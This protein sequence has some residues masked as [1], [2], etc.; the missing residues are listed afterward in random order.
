MAHDAGAVVVLEQEDVAG[1][2]GFDVPAVDE[3]D[4]GL[5]AEEGAADACRLRLACRDD[6]DPL[7]ELAGFGLPALDDI[8]PEALRDGGRV[9]LVSF[10]AAGAAEVAGEGSACEG[11]Q[12]VLGDFAAELD[13]KFLDAARGDMAEEVADA[14][15]EHKCRAEDREGFGINAGGIDGVTDFAME[16]SGADGLRNLDAHTLLSFDGGSAEMRG[17]DDV[18]KG[19]EGEVQWWRLDLE[20][21]E[22]RSSEVLALEGF[23]KGSF[24]NKATAGAIDDARAARQQGDAA[25][26]EDV[27]GFVRQRHVEGEEVHAGEE[28]VEIINELGLDG[29]GFGRGEVGVVS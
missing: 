22:G 24:I 17:E 13:D 1:G 16:E 20:D 29:A 5:V 4:A 7:R 6:L 25:G 18:G 21:V 9:D 12:V 2:G 23:V 10:G 3:D 26:I 14:F 27:A 19:A 15:A 8:E 28:L 11:A